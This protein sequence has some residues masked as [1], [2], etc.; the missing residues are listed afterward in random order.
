MVLVGGGTLMPSVQDFVSRLT[1]TP[2]EVTLPTL[3][4]AKLLLLDVH[5]L[6]VTPHFWH[7]GPTGE[8]ERSIAREPSQDLRLRM[9][10][11]R[12]VLL[13]Y[14]TIPTSREGIQVML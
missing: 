14:I 12:R 7:P 8:Y 9:R 6:L 2:L 10:A 13:Y 1:G 3:L 4:D 5:A 11:P